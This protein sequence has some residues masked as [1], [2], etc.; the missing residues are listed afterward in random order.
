MKTQTK[1]TPEET[2]SL[3]QLSFI[4]IFIGLFFKYVHKSSNKLKYK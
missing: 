1:I 3:N 4:K 2:I